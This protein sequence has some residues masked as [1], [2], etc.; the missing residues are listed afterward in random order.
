VS[1]SALTAQLVILTTIAKASNFGTK[2]VVCWGTLVVTSHCIQKV[3]SVG[4][5]G[6]NLVRLNLQSSSFEIIRPLN[7]LSIFLM[8]VS[9]IESRDSTVG[10]ATGYGLGG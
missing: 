8:L 6:N 9:I 2:C 10:I 3:P 7:M 5:T 1:I 4:L